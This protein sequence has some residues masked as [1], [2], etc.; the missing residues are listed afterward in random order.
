M[1][2]E[3]LSLAFSA[4]LV[5]FLN[6]CG[7]ALLPVYIAYYFKNEGL[8]KSSA[9]KRLFYGGI[10]GLV[11]SLGFIFTFSVIGIIINLIGKGLMQYLGYID[12]TIGFILA[13][14]GALFIF[15]LNEKIGFSK[16]TN[17]GEKLKSN[18][19]KNK[20]F[21]FF[22]YGIGFAVAAVGCSFPIFL[23][24]MAAA[25]KEQALSGFFAFIS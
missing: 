23:F 15:N 3:L 25:L 14:V 5:T 8:E 9:V 24:V 11:V 2:T 1:N 21:S 19:I 16:I 12:F 10:F 7:F 17:L 18:R 4:G 13:S 20:Y 6:P 22:I